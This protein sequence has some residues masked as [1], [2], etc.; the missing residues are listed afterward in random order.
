MQQRMFY[1]TVKVE[2][3]SIFYRDSARSMHRCCYYFLDCH[4]RLECSSLSYRADV[5]GRDDTRPRCGHFALDPATDEIAG[6][7]G[8]S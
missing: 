1:R 2:G 7:I 3:L 4:L 5:S 6:Y 8:N